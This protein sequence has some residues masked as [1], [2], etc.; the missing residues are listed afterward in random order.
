ML[1]PQLLDIYTDYLI[2]ST[3]QT[4]A[5]GLSEL[6]NGQYSHDK[7]TRFLNQETY[8]P[9]RYWQFIK[10]TVRRIEHDDGVIDVDDTIEEKPYTDEND[11]VCWHFD[12]T[13]A[14]ARQRDEYPEFRLS[15]HL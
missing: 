7:I 5:T 6:L 13:Q 10:P 2:A 1:D 12:H 9:K 4:T 8:S 3:A 14:H 15:P 11:I